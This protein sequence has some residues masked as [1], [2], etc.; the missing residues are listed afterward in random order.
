MQP[1]PVPLLLAPRFDPKI[2]GGRR[3]ATLLGKRLPPEHPF[4]ES[5]ES[6]TT[7]V[8]VNGPLPGATIGE[9]LQ[10]R[11]EWLL[12]PLGITAQDP[13]N[14]FP[15]L[16]K[17]IDATDVLS[18]QV[19]PNDDEALP[20]RKRGK[21][22]AWH[23]IHAEP[24]AKL[25]TGLKPGISRAEIAEAIQNVSLG[26]LVVE[27][28]V[29]TGDTLLIPAGTTH[30]IGEGI[31][32]YEIQQASDVTYRMYDWGRLDDAGMPRELHVDQSLEVVKP[33]LR[34]DRIAPLVISPERIMLAACRYFA[35]E[36]WLLPANPLTVDFNHQCFRLISVI[37]GS[38]T[39]QWNAETLEVPV[40]QTVLIPAA[41]SALDMSG[42]AKALVSYV[43]DLD[44]EVIAPLIAAGHPIED[45]DRLAGMLGH[46]GNA[47]NP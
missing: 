46:I 20:L 39:I 26:H 35:L 34:A 13:F 45:I 29:T 24:G 10:H 21:T 14:D 5:L 4:G 40:G 47:R 12:G 2:W 3:L 43:P 44:S 38:L 6:D 27:Q 31:L 22:E 42:P 1:D 32:L 37:D 15:L 7:S 16:A 30:A 25:I 9:L 23:I 11:R 41:T 17:F 18:V 8:V 19:H 36:Q 33:D 28:T